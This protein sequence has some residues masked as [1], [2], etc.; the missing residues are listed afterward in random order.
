MANNKFTPK[1]L[2][3]Y[4]KFLDM[5]ERISG[6]MK[7]SSTSF[8]KAAVEIS[9]RKEDIRK[10]Q[11]EINRL[12]QEEL[13]IQKAMQNLS[14]KELDAA[15]KQLD[16]LKQQKKQ[17]GDILRDN[18]AMVTAL[19]KQSTS[20]KNMSV[21]VSRDLA[22]GFK[23]MA[24][25]LKKITA[26]IKT[27]AL[28][29]SEQD[30]QIRRMSVNV[31]IL[32]KQQYNLRK[33][34]YQTAIVTQRWGVDAAKLG[35]MY[36][37]YVDDV[38]RLIPLTQAAGE[39]MAKMAMGT[40]LGAEGAA[41]MASEMEVFGKSI[42]ETAKY[43]EDVSNMSRKMG[44]NSGKV[45][46]TLS[47]NLRQAQGVNFKGGINGMAK[48][49]ALATKLR[50]EFSTA[51]QFAQSL[52]EPEKAI[53]VGAQL[54]MMGGEFAKMGDPLKLMNL[55][56]TDPAKLTE[57]MA[58]AV[59]SITKSDLSIPTMELQKLKQVAEATGISY[60][61]LI[62]MGKEM[63]QKQLVGSMLDPKMGKDMKEFVQNTAQMK[64][65]KF[66]LTVGDKT[67]EVSK[68]NQSMVSKMMA[69]S[70]TLAKQA[71]E[72][73]SASER[74]SNFLK[75]F[76]N[77][78]YLFFTGL[79]K[80][81][82]GPLEKLM[83]TGEGGLA[84]FGK[85]AVQLGETV[86]K[87]IGNVL[88]P[89]LQQGI[90]MFVST[91]KSIAQKIGEFFQSDTWETLKDVGSAFLQAGKMMLSALK[92]IKDTFGTTGL[93]ATILLIRFPKI[94]TGAFQIL[95]GSLGGLFSMLKGGAR[96][97]F[98]NP[99]Y[100]SVVGGGMGGSGGGGGVAD[101]IGGSTMGKGFLGRF[102]SKQGRAV[103]GRAAQMGKFGKFSKVVGGGAKLIG[104]L[105]KGMR[106]ANPLMWASM[107]LDV[108]RSFLDDPNSD[109]GKGLGVASTTAGDAATG[110]L[111]GSV[112]PGVGTL[113]GGIV[114]GVIGLGRSLYSE[115]K[116][117]TAEKYKVPKKY[118]NMGT[119]ASYGGLMLDG[120][121]SPGGNVI[122]TAKGELWQTSPG[123]YIT[124]S[125]PGGGS[126]MGG[127]NVN[128]N[129]SGTIEL[130][131]N[132]TVLDKNFLNDPEVKHQITRIVVDRMK[133]GSR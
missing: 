25:G 85:R 29:F 47:T 127:G 31:G 13:A 5:Q 106:A 50:I 51:T 39:A 4:E 41:Q 15:Q 11:S 53:E 104:N 89:L 40:G 61:E 100:V 1:D 18:Q 75:S 102:G 66:V 57:N 112:I 88:I 54:Q 46:K 125:Q 86:G 32:G 99:M 23:S 10:V 115:F 123:D 113:I 132:G 73:Q 97:S 90:P 42:E 64:D 118:Q 77:F 63:K 59:A 124:V 14:G 49:A 105:G 22:K 67:V 28:A 120:Q 82:R 12:E 71:E 8:L 94:I 111:I 98:S 69:Q 56:R 35:E 103:L 84:N 58:K 81:L 21:A 101:M 121:V 55:G 126:S 30:S 19:Q 95:K 87:W 131:S 26:E 16:L 93:L 37:S 36:G 65:G 83:G 133:N 96:G 110:A 2:N 20:L 72:A 33:T 48:M 79:E 24:G 7:E 130:R 80:S 44:L 91:V 60:E 27:Q 17:Y 34:L 9:K 128:V 107:G 78:A 114:G 117:R 70:Q 109:L 76:K 68:L 45:L 122:T 6:K 129:V 43:V 62:T 92:W 38:G 119:G 108:G 3:E 116:D 52:W 74:F